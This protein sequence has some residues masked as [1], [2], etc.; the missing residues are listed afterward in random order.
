M[1]IDDHDIDA[2]SLRPIKCLQAGRA[3]IDGDNQC[4]ASIGKAVNRLGIGAVTL[5]QPVRDVDPRRQLLASQ[6]SI[7]QGRRS[8]S[9]DIIITEDSDRFLSFYGIGN[10]ASSSVHIGECRWIRHQPADGRI[11]EIRG[12]LPGHTAPGEYPCQQLR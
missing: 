8:S 12:L 6:K 5:E 10:P 9:I 3:A 2:A 4:G 1:M 11:E 7:Q